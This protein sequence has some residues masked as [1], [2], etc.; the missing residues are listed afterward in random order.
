MRVGVILIAVMIV[1]VKR[2][3][4]RKFFKT[5]LKVAVQAALVVVYEHAR[6]DV[7]RVYKTKALAD[8][9][10]GESGFDLR[11]DIHI[12]AASFGMKMK[13]PFGMISS[14]VHPSFITLPL[15]RQGYKPSSEEL[16]FDIFR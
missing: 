5:A 7:H 1:L 6:H 2:L 4:R 9:A 16:S 8:T 11:G 13:V 10:F 3:I 14:S 12:C 15:L